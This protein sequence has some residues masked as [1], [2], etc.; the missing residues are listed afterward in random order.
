MTFLKESK[1]EE[2]LGKVLDMTE[3]IPLSRNFLSIWVIQENKALME[4]TGT[5]SARY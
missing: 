5:L 3:S 2:G 1:E 4:L